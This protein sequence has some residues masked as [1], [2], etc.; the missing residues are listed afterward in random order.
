MSCV[1]LKTQLEYDCVP[2]ETVSGDPAFLIQTQFN[3]TDGEPISFY[4]IDNKKTIT[5]T[6]D[7][8]S[9]FHMH[10]M[11]LLLN[12]AGEPSKY[13]YQRIR[14][15][16]SS[17]SKGVALSDDG[18]IISVGDKKKAKQLLHD[19]I[20]SLVLLSNYEKEM[21]GIPDD[22][23]EFVYRVE[24]Y[25]KSLSLNEPIIR[26]AKVKGNSNKEH[27]FDFQ[28]GN[29]LVAAVN[30]SPQAIG[31]LLRRSIDVLKS[32]ANKELSLLAVF[33]DASDDLF[34]SAA[35]EMDIVSSVAEV[36]LF[37][38]INESLVTQS[39]PKI[40]NRGTIMH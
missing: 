28:I 30:P 11:G 32:D 19:Y 23:N 13:G 39:P 20:Y 12:K 21:L 1:W 26:N 6:D 27:T 34:G 14:S 38:Q 25:L 5:I 3:W 4:V 37:S 8:D 36:T 40:N 18:E 24:Q 31:G 29:K 10:G 9:I 16:V 33:D 17:V 22:D 7:A 2:Y 15:I 35:E